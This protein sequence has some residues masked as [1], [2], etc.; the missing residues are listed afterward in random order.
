MDVIHN[1]CNMKKQIIFTIG[2][3]VTTF[4]VLIVVAVSAGFLEYRVNPEYLAEP[5]KSNSQ[6][7]I[8]RELAHN[9][10]EYY[11]NSDKEFSVCITTEKK[12]SYSEDGTNLKISYLLNNLDG[13]IEYSGLNYAINDYCDEGIIHSHPKG[14]C[15]LSL[16]DIS[17]F[18]SRIAQ[19]EIFTVVMCGEDNFVYITRNNFL[20]S[21][22]II[23]S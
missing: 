18:K 15:F 17:A 9:L 13:E 23:E 10:N 22:V 5:T 21:K 8:T 6:F 16:S 4:L 1:R 3:I 11:K 20:E 12:S 7:T 14:S 19:G 2:T